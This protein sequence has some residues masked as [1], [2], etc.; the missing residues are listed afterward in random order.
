MSTALMGG[1]AAGF[2]LGALFG[3]WAGA[4]MAREEIRLAICRADD[5][6]AAAG[7]S[8]AEAGRAQRAHAADPAQTSG[9]TGHFG[10]TAPE[11]TVPAPP[12]IGVR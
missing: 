6:E 10:L 11:S 7:R 4:M 12:H 2:L 8:A 3:L 9:I 5:A 1:L